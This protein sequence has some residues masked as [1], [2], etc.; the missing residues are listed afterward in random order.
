[1]YVDKESVIFVLPTKGC[2]IPDALDRLTLRHGIMKRKINDELFDL[3]CNRV[4]C[5]ILLLIAVSFTSRGSINTLLLIA[6]DAVLS[7]LLIFR[8]LHVQKEIRM[9][10]RNQFDAEKYRLTR[11][12]RVKTR[13]ILGAVASVLLAVYFIVQI[14]KAGDINHWY[15]TL[16]LIVALG[17]VLW[18]SIGVDRGQFKD[19]SQDKDPDSGE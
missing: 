10:E 16:I 9:A 7:L 15:E 18:G 6:I 14:Y 4:A 1:L 17:L 2:F 19:L 13:M 11:I 5:P 3:W 8:G 12:R